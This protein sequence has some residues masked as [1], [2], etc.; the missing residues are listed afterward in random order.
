MSKYLRICGV[1]IGTVL[2]TTGCATII[3]PPSQAEACG[4]SSI[5][6]HCLFL[7]TKA[8]LSLV[9]ADADWITA[10]SEYAHAL[11]VS[12]QTDEALE[13]LQ[14]ALERASG[15]EAPVKRAKA[16]TSIALAYTAA[17]DLEAALAVADTGEALLTSVDAEA[18]RWDLAG[19]FF[20]TR[21]KSGDVK[22][23]VEAAKSMP[24]LGEALA[25]YKARTLREVAVQQAKTGDFL[26]A[27]ESLD[28]MT[29]GLSYYRATARADIAA[30]ALEQDKLELIPD[31]ITEAELIARAQDNG[32]FVAGA[33][34]DIAEVEMHRGNGNTATQLFADAMDGARTAKS[35][36]ERARS[37]SRVVTGMS[38]TGVERIDHTYLEEALA[39][40]DNE[41]SEQM[42][43][44]SLYEIA[45]S[46]AFSGHFELANSLLPRLPETPFGDA[47]SLKSA[48]QR[49]IAWGLARHGQLDKAVALANKIET[50]RE[51]VQTLSRIIRLLDNPA[52]D[53]FPRYL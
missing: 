43:N 12:N 1:I 31:L 5:S 14:H 37:L 15:I 51:R 52:M 21:A 17:G 36:Q 20:T 29:M 41:K 30:L 34:R 8:S 13:L 24:Q 16:L 28:L 35:A 22:A 4:E 32:Y 3:E 50:P 40:A 10:A 11:S 7:S 49:D 6:K 53:A 9:E 47:H 46:A 42:K 27:R 23:A 44:F 48:T 39:F 19:K 33:L 38:D 25:A 18:K 26:G 45:G 2:L